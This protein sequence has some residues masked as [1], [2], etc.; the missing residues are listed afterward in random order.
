MKKSLLIGLSATAVTIGVVGLAGIASAQTSNTSGGTS[1]IDKIATKFNLKKADVQAV[2]D[3]DRSDHEAERAAKEK[4]TLDAAVK[5]GT[6]TQSQEDQ[7]IAK[8]QEMKTYMD[9]LKDKTETDRRTAMKAKMDE[10]KQWLTD[11]KIPDS[12][13]QSLHMGGPGDGR[14]HDGPPPA[15]GAAPSDAPATTN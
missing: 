10:F 2:F 7:L 9:S 15:D 13:M 4:T 12:L 5:A 3:Q 11:N 14:G 8:Q 6:I 1:L